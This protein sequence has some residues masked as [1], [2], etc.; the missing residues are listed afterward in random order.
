[1][2]VLLL[3]TLLTTALCALRAEDAPILCLDPGGHTAAIKQVL[4]TPD[5][6]QLISVGEDKVIRCWDTSTGETLRTLHGQIGPGP[7]GK[8]YAAAI[9][10][11]G[12]TLAVGGYSSSD[13]NAIRLIELHTGVVTRLLCGHENVISSLAFS[14]DGATLASGSADNTVRLWDADSGKCRRVLRGHAKEVTSVAFSWDGRQVASASFDHTARVWEV[15]T[16]ATRFILRG[17]TAEVGTLAWSPDGE[18][19]A[20]GSDDQTIRLWNADD[21]Q[22]RQTLPR[23][24]NQV[25]CL[26]FSPD[27]RRLLSGLGGRPGEFTV[28]LWSLPKG[29]VALEFT[30]HHDTVM[31]VAFSPDGKTVASAGGDNN[32]I[33][34]WDAD[35]GV[36][37]QRLA[38]RGAEAHSIA[39][40][41]DSSRVAWGNQAVFKSI[42]E[43]G[44]LEYT[45]DLIAGRPGEAVQAGEQWQRA[46]TERD[47]LK[48]AVSDDRLNLIIHNG[49]KETAHL[50]ADT[51]ILCTTLTPTGEVVLGTGFNLA[52]YDSYGAGLHNFVGHTEEV[53]A[54]AASPDG[55]YLASVSYDQTVRIWPLRR[56]RDVV[57]ALLGTVLDV[58][59]NTL[60]LQ[61]AVDSVAPLLTIFRSTD[62]EWVAW[63]PEGYYACSPGAER[64]I[65]WQVNRGEDKAA[66]YYPAYQFRRTLYRPDVIC[67]LLQAGSTAKAVKLADA[68]RKKETDPTLT[69]A[70]I[71]RFLPPKVELLEPS[72]GAV[73][74][75]ATMTVHVRVKDPN[76]RALSGV[77]LLVNGRKTEGHA[78]PI[79]PGKQKADER[80]WEV[81]LLPGENKLSVLAVN[82]AGAESVP[83]SVMVTYHPAQVLDDATEKPALYM[84]AIGVSNYGLQFPDKDAHDFAAIYQAQEGKLFRKVTCKILT[85]ADASRDNILDA[86]DWLSKVVTQRDWAMVYLAGHGVTDNLDQYYFAPYNIDLHRLKSTGIVWSIFRNKLADLPGMVF[87]VLDTCQAASVTGEKTRGLVAYNDVVR[88]ASTDE[89]GLITLASCKYNETSR[90]R[91]DWHNG[92]FTLALVEALSGKADYSHNGIITISEVDAYVADRVKELTSDC[93]HPT[94][95]CP[96][97]IWSGLPMAIK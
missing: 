52:L 50:C 22:L 47:G 33:Y 36:E 48:L 80:R 74:M 31:D 28:R 78:L 89:V 41:A 81:T 45:F 56:K 97:T 42:N 82:D 55:R 15:A 51:A 43:R 62:G 27:S 11:D 88:D 32:E 37:K 60:P 75:T 46:I 54:V 86:L 77:T 66:D 71:T 61:P 57:S 53:L 38:G 79:A 96:S 5:G 8:L 12:Q 10:P 16:G 25:T 94:I 73:T 91:T 83:V 72:A 13:A 85:D 87:L 24:G 20:T 65:G 2:R 95:D 21:G 92:A 68:W 63:T 90:E 34:L 64:M 84:L 18:T 23:Q 70:T 19:I 9:S 69:A 49:G 35:T 4:F 3:L 76:G 59:V 1:M 29:T 39:W 17:H 6:R 26:A 7:E 40:S 93:Q 67:R 44:P 14:P 30:K 58:V